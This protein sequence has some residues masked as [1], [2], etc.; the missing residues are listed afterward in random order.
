MNNVDDKT[1]APSGRAPRFLES[2]A[3][4]LGLKL[5]GSLAVLFGF[6]AVHGFAL[7]PP[8]ERAGSQVPPAAPP[9]TREIHPPDVFVRAQF[10]LDELDLIR[11][12]MGKP[13]NKQ[14]EIAVRNVAPREVFFQA[15]AFYQKADRLCFERTR[16]SGLPIGVPEGT[17][18]PAHVLA[19]IDAALERIKLVKDHFG[20]KQRSKEKPR[21]PTKTPTDVFRAVV[22]GNRQLN[23]LLERRFSPSDVYQEVTLAVNYATRLRAHFPGT[24]IPALPAFE[25]DKRPSDVYRRLVG[26][27]DRIRKVEE[28][29][30]LEVLEF[31]PSN[32]EIEA[33]QPSDVYDIAS[34]VVSEL[35]F[36]LS[37]LEG[38]SPP[39]PAYYP[40]RKLPSHV[41]Q[42]VGLLEA[43][44]IELQQLAG[45]NPQW[46]PS[47]R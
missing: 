1:P 44:L 35:A 42:R 38:A 19:V 8:A 22:Q 40:G 30:H 33:V 15:L 31:D 14:P 2:H 4:A 9:E 34:L 20:I 21:N 11:S 18:H 23:L 26:C 46:L 12:W 39:R 43:Q 24:R 41:Y 25:S 36:L 5:W 17:I 13:R 27:F 28:N 32:V 37:N 3:G 7:D 16:E 6:P 10:A 47:S 45:A 29:S